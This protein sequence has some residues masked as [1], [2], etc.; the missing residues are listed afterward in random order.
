MRTRKI[1]ELIVEHE[2]CDTQENEAGFRET[3]CTAE[4]GECY[5]GLFL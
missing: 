4:F 1:N 5:L 3:R 2:K